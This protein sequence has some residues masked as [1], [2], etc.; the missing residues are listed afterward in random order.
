LTVQPQTSA[1][2]ATRLALIVAAIAALILATFYLVSP[3]LGTHVAPVFVDGNASC[4][5]LN[6]AYDHEFKIEPVTGGLHN[7]PSSDFSVTLTL[8]NTADGQTF[9][10]VS[11]LPVDAVFAKGG[12]EGNLY[13]YAPPATADT[14]LHAPANASGDWAGLSHISFCFND[15]PEESEA[16]PSQTP[17]GSEGGS[18]STPTPTPE[19]SQGGGTGTPEPSQTPEGSQAGA[20]GTPAASLPNTALGL[21][22]SGTLATIFFGAVLISALGALAYANVVAVRR[23][24]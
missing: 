6:V 23:R 12:S 16:P 13:V 15:V 24:R 10:W 4:G 19:G 22:A 7:D 11:N 5:Q 20:T 1:N 9:D 17:E 8:H 2:H 21:P 3:V 18:T 14:G